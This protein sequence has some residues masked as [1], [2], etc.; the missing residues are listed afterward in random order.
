MV[1]LVA[2]VEN[3]DF[4]AQESSHFITSMGDKRLFIAEF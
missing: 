1:V 4:I 2:L 3:V